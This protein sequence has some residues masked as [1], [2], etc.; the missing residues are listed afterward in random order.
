[1]CGGDFPSTRN[2]EEDSG[3]N[4]VGVSARVYPGLANGETSP[5]KSG[6]KSLSSG[7][8]RVV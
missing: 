2:A 8:E 1:M 6:N 3:E 4:M 7:R 5:C